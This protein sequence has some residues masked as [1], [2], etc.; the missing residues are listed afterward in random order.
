MTK[1]VCGFLF[2]SRMKDVVLIWKNKPKWQAGKLNGIGGKIELGESADDAMEREFM[3]ETGLN[4]GNWEHFITLS[5]EDW[6]VHFFCAKDESNQ[7]EYAET[8]EDEEVAKIEVARL[9]DF[10]FIPN[11]EWLIPMAMHK[12]ENPEERM[13]INLI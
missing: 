7:F 1:Y 4:V 9:H 13:S 11:L 3:E 10:D 12:I 8:K 5:G 2:D 6:M